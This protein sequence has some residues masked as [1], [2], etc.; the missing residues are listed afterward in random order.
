MTYKF[1]NRHATRGINSNVPL[2]VQ[3]LLWNLISNLI[4]KKVQVDYLQVFEFNKHDDSVIEIIHRQE[5]PEIINKHYIKTD[6]ENLN[7]LVNKTIF[8]ID[9]ITHSTMLFSEEY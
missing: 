7:K 9:D 6:N 4:N 3:L 2:E 5:E 1:Q 8:V